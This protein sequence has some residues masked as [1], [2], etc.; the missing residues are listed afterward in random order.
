MAEC[1]SQSKPPFTTMVDKDCSKSYASECTTQVPQDSLSDSLDSG[2]SMETGTSSKMSQSRLEWNRG[3]TRQEKKIKRAQKHNE[4]K[5]LGWKEKEQLKVH[6]AEVALP[7]L[8]GSVAASQHD[9]IIEQKKNEPTPDDNEKKS[10]Q[11]PLSK[12]FQW[13]CVNGFR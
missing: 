2:A 3:P 1:S 11:M 5:A 9:M 7:G 4:E 6:Q 13:T 12:K 8:K 10:L